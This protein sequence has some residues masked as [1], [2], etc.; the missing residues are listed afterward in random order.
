[1]Y[2]FQPIATRV[3][4]KLTQ[5]ENEKNLTYIS[6]STGCSGSEAIRKRGQVLDA[7]IAR[8][9]VPVSLVLIA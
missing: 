1:M 6:N 8:E 3:S 7:T 9:S 4:R 5:R 2:V